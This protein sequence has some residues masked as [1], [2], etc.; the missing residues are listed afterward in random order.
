MN[1]N[2][3]KIN[4]IDKESTNCD[5]FQKDNTITLDFSCYPTRK[6]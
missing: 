3:R 5:D 6:T 4:F 1:G 2:K